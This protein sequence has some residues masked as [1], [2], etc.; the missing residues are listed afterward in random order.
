M[1]DPDF[2]VPLRIMAYSGVFITL[3]SGVYLLKNA[4][5][6]FG[7][8]SDMPS[9]SSGVRSYTNMQA[10]TVWLLTLKLFAFLAFAL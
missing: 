3:L 5:R 9:E 7:R 8:T 4:N 10:F 2:L 1:I 6:L